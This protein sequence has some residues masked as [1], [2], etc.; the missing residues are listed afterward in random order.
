[1]SAT[2]V[3]RAGK[4]GNICV[5]NNVST[6]ICPRLPGPSVVS[7]RCDVDC[8]GNRK[9]HTGLTKDQ[10]FRHNSVFCFFLF[11]FVLSF[12]HTFPCNSPICSSHKHSV[13]C[14]NFRYVLK[15]KMAGQI[16]LS[17]SHDVTTKY[18]LSF[19][20][21]SSGLS[22]HVNLVHRTLTERKP[23]EGVP[24]TLPFYLYHNGG[25]RPNVNN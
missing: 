7:I 18:L 11:F 3:A 21:A 9:F 22:V 16:S 8:H 14:C 25:V 5:G 20:R 4:Q 1:M 15:S 6:T 10:L 12:V 13:F 23:S 17:T 2:N 24:F 19:C